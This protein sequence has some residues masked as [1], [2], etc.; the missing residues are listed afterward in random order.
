M[1]PAERAKELFIEG[2][3]CAESVLMA[4]LESLGIEAE[5]SPRV[6][7]GFAAG[8][9]G[10]GMVCG[11]LS[12]AIIAAGWRHGRSSLTDDRDKLM[13]ITRSLVDAFQKE[14]GSASCR[15]L[16]G[17]DLTDAAERKRA[18]EEGIFEKTCVPLVE[19][20]AAKMAASL[21]ES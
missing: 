15:M 11:A 17:L 8:I 2:W 9:G 7:T 5:W 10:T 19:F 18:R 6:A 1:E 20:C 4:V 21:M 3:S 14:F 13:A 12:G 16:T